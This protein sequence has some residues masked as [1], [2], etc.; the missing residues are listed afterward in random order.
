MAIIKDPKVLLPLIRQ[1]MPNVIASQL[2]GV[3][4]MSGPIGQIHTLR[5]RYDY[6]NNRDIF[7]MQ[8]KHY[9]HFTKA[10]NRRTK[11]KMSYLTGLG[12]TC[13][14]VNMDLPRGAIEAKAY[15]KKYV[16]DGAWISNGNHFVFAYDKDVTLFALKF[17]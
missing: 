7:T 1:V 9:Q 16:K 13:V 17:T 15:C 14:K 11:Q 12:Y 6:L 4:P 5:T 10:Y 3:Q 2:I 8:K